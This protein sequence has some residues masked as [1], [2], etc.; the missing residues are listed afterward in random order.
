MLILLAFHQ[1]LIDTALRLSDFRGCL[2]H[3]VVMQLRQFA[4]IIIVINGKGRLDLFCRRHRFISRASTSPL[5]ASID[6]LLE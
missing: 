5:R 3:K 4:E 2:L 6:K 1:E